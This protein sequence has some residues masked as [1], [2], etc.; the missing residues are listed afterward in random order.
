MDEAHHHPG[1]GAGVPRRVSQSPRGRNLVAPLSGLLRGRSHASCSATGKPF[2]C[3]PCPLPPHAGLSGLGHIAPAAPSA[4]DTHLRRPPGSRR[5][6]GTEGVPLPRW[7]RCRGA[8]EQKGRHGA[9]S[10]RASVL[11]PTSTAATAPQQ[12]PERRRC[13]SRCDT[14][15]PVPATAGVAQRSKTA[16]ASTWWVWGNMSAMPAAI[17]R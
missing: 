8:T 5:K 15:A 3:T 6:P 7:R 9:L 16:S 17:S 11:P 2:D 1:R 14:G 4:G 12:S 10:L 13:A